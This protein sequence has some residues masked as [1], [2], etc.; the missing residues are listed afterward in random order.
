MGEGGHTCACARAR[1]QARPLIRTHARGRAH[2]CARECRRVSVRFRTPGCIARAA[3]T[4]A[5]MPPACVAVQSTTSSSSSSSPPRAGRGGGGGGGFALL[6]HG[7]QR[8][9][10]GALGV[11]GA[12]LEEGDER[13]PAVEVPAGRLQVPHLAR[14]RAHRRGRQAERAPGQA[15]GGRGDRRPQPRR[16]SVGCLAVLDGRGR[17]AERGGRQPRMARG[18]PW[19]S[20]CTCRLCHVSLVSRIGAGGSHADSSDPCRS[21]RRRLRLAAPPNPNPTPQRQ[22]SEA[23]TEQRPK[24]RASEHKELLP[25]GAATVN[26]NAWYA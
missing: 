9:G 24:R 11:G 10:G 21:R 16:L 14:A 20:E 4:C 5:P 13:R 8:G 15:L 2:I 1:P 3:R 12:P 26:L 19:A 17:P 25:G 7:E 18:H 22:H 6:G 23:P